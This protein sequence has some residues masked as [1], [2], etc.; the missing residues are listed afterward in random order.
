MSEAVSL[1]LRGDSLLGFFDMLFSSPSNCLVQDVTSM[2]LTILILSLPA[3]I[4]F[5]LLSWGTF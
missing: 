1:F 5:T 4:I 3:V 2:F